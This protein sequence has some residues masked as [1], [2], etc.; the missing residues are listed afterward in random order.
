MLINVDADE[1]RVA[2]TEGGRLENL[3]LETRNHDQVKGN[4]YKGVVHKV[5][6]SFQAA[7]V[8][9]GADKQ[10]FLPL[11]E[12]HPNLYPKGLDKN[13][14][15][16]QILKPKQ[17]L[18]VQVVRDEIGNKGA[19]LST[20]L[21]VPGRYL[22]LISES[23]KSGISRKISDD[24]R[25]RLKDILKDMEMP[26]G[27]G[28][29]VR[30]AGTEC[31]EEELH[32]DLAYLTKMWDVIQKAYDERKRPGLLYE[33]RSLAVRSVRDYF[34]EDIT[35]VLIDDAMAHQEVLEFVGVLMPQFVDVFKHYMGSVPLFIKQGIEDQI[36]EVFS[37]KV[38]LR[39]GGSIVIDSTE[40]LVAIDVNSGRVKG[41]GIEDTAYTTN[42]EAAR[43]LARQV[44]IR[45]LGGLIIV[46]FIDMRDRKR[47]REV[48]DTLRDA[49][50]NDKARRKFARISEFG[51]LEMSRQRLSSTLMRASFDRCPHC[52]GQGVIRTPESAGMYLLRRVREATAGGRLHQVVV[53]APTPVANFLLNRKRREL[54]M[55][56]V[57]RR[58]LVEVHADTEL[59]PTEAT[60]ESL[61]R[62]GRGKPTQTVQKIDLVQSETIRRESG[63]AKRGDVIFRDIPDAPN[64][65]DVYKDIE[66]NA[67]SITSRAHASRL[68]SETRRLKAERERNQQLKS[69]EPSFLQKIGAWLKGLFGSAEP[70]KPA[71]PARRR[72]P[73]SRGSER[74]RDRRDSS[75]R[76]GG[77]G[78]RGRKNEGGRNDNRSSRGEKKSSRTRSA[79]SNTDSRSSEEKAQ[80]KSTQQT[81]Q[82]SEAAGEDGPVRR[83][84]RRRGR[85]GRGAR[86]GE[87]GEE[88]GNENTAAASLSSASAS[89]DDKEESRG[90]R[91][92]RGRGGR[93]RNSGNEAKTGA[94][95]EGS[96]A[97][98]ESPR[99]GSAAPRAPRAAASAPESA[100][101]PAPKKAA[102]SIPSAPIAKPAAA[103]LP[104]TPPPAAA[105]PKPASPFVI[106]LR[107]G[108][109]GTSSSA[110]AD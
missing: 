75:E 102:D 96:N 80:D 5:E 6:A 100:P 83:R 30:T 45:D 49:F 51:L 35:E 107:G 64:F 44:I 33:D 89:S 57:E 29:I 109:P 71:R 106:D 37:R 24:E 25:D 22:V 87:G 31:S 95:G 34:T 82:R 104:M 69:M 85:R 11:S 98:P 7:F 18:M 43:E 68:E 46:D 88:S 55:L 108:R 10:G 20:H 76:R 103:S 38:P 110:D 1:S 60:L 39:S 66:D 56:E 23:D 40:A 67:A 94:N 3:E 36:E 21:S 16:T 92:R 74:S 59:L 52:A 91:S 28:T 27:F 54:Y 61:E 73:S 12:I 14:S 58:V 86:T 8:D 63:N 9:F 13:A 78:T 101:S 50:K 79:A 19:T 81:T 4:V 53:R 72:T 65:G 15:I 32:K 47:I 93:N 105:P 62:K 77:R 48:E 26:K 70:E 97:A 42:L 41:D 84:R 2:I 17:E 90:G 99:E